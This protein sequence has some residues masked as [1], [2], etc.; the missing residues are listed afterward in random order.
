[1][2]ISEILA[3]Y[4]KSD[5]F[6]FD[7]CSQMIVEVENWIVRGCFSHFQKYGKMIILIFSMSICSLLFSMLVWIWW[8]LTVDEKANT[9]IYEWDYRCVPSLAYSKKRHVVWARMQEKTE[10]L[11]YTMF[12][13]YTLQ[14]Y[15]SI[16]GFVGA[17]VS[18]MFD[19]AWMVVT[20][21]QT[22]CVHSYV[23]WS[24]YLLIYLYTR[25]AFHHVIG[26]FIRIMIKLYTIECKY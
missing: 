23:R 11:V 22:H 18:C 10:F 12:L 4:L 6:G 17:F 21:Q 13:W 3:T 2:K 7:V 5:A 16:H 14:L 1:M 15:A 8:Q 25:Y 20:N 24:V 26:V 19:V 9:L